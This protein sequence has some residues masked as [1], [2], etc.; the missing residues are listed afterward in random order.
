M[1]S[2]ARHDDCCHDCGRRYCCQSCGGQNFQENPNEPCSCDVLVTV[3]CHDY[4]NLI[5][6]TFDK[7]EFMEH[8]RTHTKEHPEIGT[9]HHLP[10]HTLNAPETNPFE[11]D[12]TQGGWFMST[13]LDK[14][15]NYSTFILENGIVYKNDFYAS[16]VCF[17]EGHDVSGAADRV[18]GCKSKLIRS[19]CVRDYLEE[20]SPSVD[21]E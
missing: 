21:D 18:I 17:K 6:H 9:I 10:T 1:S 8:I 5:T 19:L 2:C 16:L 12:A 3:H 13:D 14:L 15:L 11:F 7:A 20:E 4:G